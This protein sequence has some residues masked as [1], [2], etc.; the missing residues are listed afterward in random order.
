MTERKAN[1]WTKTKRGATRAYKPTQ[2][3]TTFAFA[4]PHTI[5]TYMVN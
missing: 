5:S 4:T 3:Y 2:G 1:A